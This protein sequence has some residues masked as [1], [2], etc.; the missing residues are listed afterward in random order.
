MLERIYSLYRFTFLTGKDILSKNSTK[1]LFD[2][3]NSNN[4]SD[5]STRA[6]TSFLKIKPIKIGNQGDSYEI[7]VGITLL[8][9]LSSDENRFFD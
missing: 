3:V 7:L 5:I 9:W 4:L 1:T 8:L 2:D 6:T